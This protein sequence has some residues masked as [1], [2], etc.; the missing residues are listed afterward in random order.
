LRLADS[1]HPRLIMASSAG[2]VHRTGPLPAASDYSKTL[3]HALVDQDSE[4]TLPMGSVSRMQLLLTSLV[5]RVHDAIYVL[6]RHARD[7]AL[8][9]PC[10]GPGPNS[11]EYA[12]DAANVL[13][14]LKTVSESLPDDGL[15]EDVFQA[16]LCVLNEELF[17]VRSD[18]KLQLERAKEAKKKIEE[19]LTFGIGA[20]GTRDN[21]P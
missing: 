16:R 19:R 5:E 1:I 8:G 11:T 7:L 2:S 21:T 10:A 17:A 3:L 6:P 13:K 18:S 4:I 9:T 20:R 12:V 14:T 15:T